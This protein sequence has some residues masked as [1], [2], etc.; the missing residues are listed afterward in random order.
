MHAKH[1]LV[2]VISGA[3]LLFSLFFTAYAQEANN[4]Y[5]PV[6]QRPGWVYLPLVTSIEPTPTPTPTPTP[7][8]TL[9]VYEEVLIPA[10]AFQMGC[11]RNNAADI[12]EWNDEL[13][14]HTVYLD[15]Y[16]ID[17]Y[18]VTNARYQE[19][20]SAG[21]CRT[22]SRTSSQT[23]P[24]YYGNETFA[25]FPVL[26]VNWYDANAFCAWEGKR[27]PTEAEWEKAA[28]GSSDT[29]TYPWGNSGL[30][31]SKGNFD[32]HGYGARVHCVG[33][34]TQVG[35][36]PDGASPYGVMDMAGNVREWVSDWY[37]STYYGVSPS[38][39]PQGPSSGT[40]RILRGGSWDNHF[41]YMRTA[42]RVNTWP[43]RNN[44]LYGFRCARSQ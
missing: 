17:K 43:E 30:D 21:V 20:V 18:E 40:N 11:D 44:N 3:T 22:P 4:I 14:L 19:C 41:N 24:S 23:R 12:C 9:D 39:N 5:L 37:S 36:Y 35:S 26:Y 7:I 27:L 6:I 31:C 34:T 16:Y 2:V 33:D 32:L 25:A 10:G 29:R 13:P 38:I 28:R 1:I 15:A 42:R 8:P